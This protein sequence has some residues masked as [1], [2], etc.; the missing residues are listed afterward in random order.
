MVEHKNYKENECGTL[1]EY[2]TENKAGDSD[3]TK[4]N[5]QDFYLNE[6]KTMI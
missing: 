2:T 1:L 5:S 3:I 4:L 6:K